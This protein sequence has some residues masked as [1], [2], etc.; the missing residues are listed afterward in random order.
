MKFRLHNE[1]RWDVYDNYDKHSYFSA[2]RE[3]YRHLATT[4]FPTRSDLLKYFGDSFFHDAELVSA[5]YDRKC[6]SLDLSIYTLND[7]EDINDYRKRHGLPLIA[8]SRY[9]RRPIRYTCHFSGVTFYQANKRFPARIM[10]TELNRGNKLGM[11]MVAV[12]FSPTHEIEFC[13]VACKV[14]VDSPARIA[15]LTGGSARIPR[16]STCRGRLLSSTKITKLLEASH[17]NTG[18]RPAVKTAL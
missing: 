8:R 13:C 16:C 5:H 1:I 15:A 4:N 17:S 3:Y 18:H 14:V 2:K 10:D 9:A 7:L 12:S 11:Y 6:A